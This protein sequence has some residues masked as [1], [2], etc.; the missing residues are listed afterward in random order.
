MELTNSLPYLLIINSI[1]IISLILT[2]NESTKDSIT[3]STSSSIVNPF[4]QFTWGSLVLQ[5]SLLLIKIKTN[6]F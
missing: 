2:Q 5:L 1:F 6:D 4:E 3:S